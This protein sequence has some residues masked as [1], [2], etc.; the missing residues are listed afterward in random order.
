MPAKDKRSN[1]GHS[2]LGVPTSA[3]QPEPKKNVFFS[4]FRN[5]NDGSCGRHWR[6]ILRAVISPTKRI[7]AG[8]EKKREKK[9][10]VLIGGRWGKRT[11]TFFMSFQCVVAVFARSPRRARRHDEDES[12]AYL[13][14]PP[15]YKQEMLNV[16][17]GIYKELI[18]PRTSMAK[19]YCQV[20]RPISTKKKEENPWP[21]SFPVVSG[22][23][24]RRPRIS[25]D[26][27]N[28]FR[29]SFDS[30]Q[31]VHNDVKLIKTKGR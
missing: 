22:S 3:R 28:Y 8:H 6:E 26:R 31:E 1:D 20:P 17:K 5:N 25:S 14:C 4:F 10:V 11:T 15:I 23:T 13:S 9:N 18:V 21:Q 29:Y 24:F 30:F 2:P 7:R 27:C 16:R 19:F 12:H